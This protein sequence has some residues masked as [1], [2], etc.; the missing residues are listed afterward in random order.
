MGTL[1]TWADGAPPMVIYLI[2]IPAVGKYT[3]AKHLGRLTGARVVDNQSINLPV[4]NVL[5][6]DGTDAFPLPE[7]AWEH[8]ATIRG[9]VLDT[10][11][12]LC[13]TS[14]SFVFTNVLEKGDAQAEA[15]FERI[16]A[17]ARDRGARFFPVRL[18]CDAAALRAR[19]D[20]PDRRARLKDIDVT[21]IERYVETFELLP[22]EHPDAFTLDTT[23]GSPEEAA[24]SILEHIRERLAGSQ[25]T[26]ADR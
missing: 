12:E 6:F 18:T 5:G 24:L 11:T 2:G 16:R 22:V 23:E 14:D 26:A 1:G 17:L 21:N 19:K 10:I 15:L 25:T 13:G 8:I 7:R 20:S 3:I 4:F 9:A